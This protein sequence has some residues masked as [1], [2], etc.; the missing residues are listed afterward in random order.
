VGV[1]FVGAG[2]YAKSVLLP[3]LADVPGVRKVAVA[4]ATGPSARR[5]AERYGFAHCGTDAMQAIETAGGDL[6]FIAT[7]HDSHAEH[8]IHALGAGKAVWL[9]KP[10]GLSNAEIDAIVEAA[11]G[12]FLVVGYNRRFSSHAR[13]I[14]D[15]FANRS[16]ALAIRYTVAAG[17]PPRASWITERAVG[18]GR[19]IGEVCHFVDTCQFLVGAPP[20][21]VYARALGR[22]ATDD[23]VVA[24][25]GWDDGSTATIEY[26]AHAGAE[27]PKERFEVSC[28]G[29]T[30]H[31]HNYRRTHISGRSDVRTFNQDKGQSAA[32]KE[33]VEAVRSGA[34]SPMTLA[35]IA[36]ASR[37]TFAIEQSIA[38]G[39]AVRIGE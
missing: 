7:R 29:K 26:L 16:T 15:A 9:E 12:K 22:D 18:G 27:L 5:T 35:E 11:R 17:A 34:A 13:A 8:A 39:A 6:V 32:V 38:T 19:V 14:R 24:L 25:L 31:C 2:N 1:S 10:A 3:A 30:A 28:D 21:T 20:R 4:T 36:A 33:I 37:V 23:S